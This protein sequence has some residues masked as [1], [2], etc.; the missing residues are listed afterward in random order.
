[1]L[2]CAVLWDRMAFAHAHVTPFV[3]E[4]KFLCTRHMTLVID[5]EKKS[6]NQKTL[7]LTTHSVFG[8]A[9]LSM[10]QILAPHTC[11]G[12]AKSNFGTAVSAPA[13]SP[14]P[15]AGSAS[16]EAPAVMSASAA[17]AS[18]AAALAAGS[19]GA[20]ANASSANKQSFRLTILREG[21]IVGY[22]VGK[23]VVQHRIPLNNAKDVFVA[24]KAPYN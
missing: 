7:K 1:V 3:S 10:R 23:S 17:G 13:S 9:A 6:D 14:S 22:L 15:S 12:P 20:F 11:V 24:D 21:Q 18:T 4:P 8:Y 19:G 5:Y 16:K 2:C